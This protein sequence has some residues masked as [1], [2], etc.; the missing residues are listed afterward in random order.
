MT[1]HTFC[2]FKVTIKSVQDLIYTGVMRAHTYPMQWHY[3]LIHCIFK[4][5]YSNVCAHI[6]ATRL[7]MYLCSFNLDHNHYLK[8]N[9]H[10]IDTVNGCVGMMFDPFCIFVIKA[11]ICE[12]LHK[13]DISI[14]LFWS[15]S[16]W[17]CHDTNSDMECHVP[18]WS[19]FEMRCTELLPF[20][21][22]GRSHG[23]SH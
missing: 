8:K 4:Y 15:S 2:E 16:M 17:R 13:R 10:N 3:I 12:R 18:W 9:W 19:V 11:T 22:S 5:I 1:R 23:T 20:S 7:R 14:S 6:F 21:N